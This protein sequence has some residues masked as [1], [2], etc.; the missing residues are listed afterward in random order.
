MIQLDTLAQMLLV[1][2]LV[3]ALGRALSIPARRLGQPVVL[4]EI[5]AGIV[6]GPAVLG[7]LWP[8]STH[9]L[10]PTDVREALSVVGGLGLVLFMFLV[11]LDF[12][13]AILRRHDRLVAKVSAGAL[14][15]PFV[16]GLG[17]AA[18][19]ARSY[20]VPAGVTHVGFDLFIATAL[21]ITA[22]PVLAR[23]VDERGLGELHVAQVS[24]AAAAVQDVAGWMLL[25]VALTAAAGTGAGTS[26]RIVLELAAFL[27]VLVC[28]VRPGLRFVLARLGPDGTPHA[29]A[30]VLVALFASAAT[31]EGIGLHSV[32]GAFALGV[33]VPRREMTDLVPRLDAAIRPLTIAVLLPVYFL[34][35]G[36]TF[37]LS[38]L[39]WETVGVVLLVVAAACIGKLAGGGLAARLGG[40][41]RSEAWTIGV[42]LNTRGLVEL[43]VLQIGFQAGIIDREVFSVLLVMALTTTLMTGPLLTL[44]GVERP[45]PEDLGEPTLTAAPMAFA[46]RASGGR[47]T[48]TSL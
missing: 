21:S 39:G 25:T 45:P 20:P 30:I 8:G 6:L 12:D 16:L 13:P 19:L 7:G 9:A 41:P 34:L 3:L 43:I 23:I 47:A 32:L 4:A 27:V 40:L 46:H 22:F 11:G 1:V 18:V 37:T 15:V 35:P 48:S 38:G 10:F 31:T 17:V 29:L 5:I 33:V 42:L 24:L 14:L 26:F 36:L 2:A 28:V 44:L